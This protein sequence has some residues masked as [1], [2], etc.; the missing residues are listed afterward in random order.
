[1]TPAAIHFTTSSSAIRCRSASRRMRS[2]ASYSSA[3]VSSSVASDMTSQYVSE[4]AVSVTRLS[5]E[6]AKSSRPMLSPSL[7]VAKT[8]SS[9]IS[10]FSSPPSFEQASSWTFPR[11]MK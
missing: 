7:S 9:S 6:L 4:R 2:D 11:E 5:C 1:M 8:A 3:P 10:P